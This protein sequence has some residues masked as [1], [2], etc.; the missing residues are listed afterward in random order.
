[1]TA[2]VFLL[3]QTERM[4]SAHTG[5]TMTWCLFTANY[6]ILNKQISLFREECLHG[7]P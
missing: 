3:A 2:T 6:E 1:M 5:F 7:D 4:D